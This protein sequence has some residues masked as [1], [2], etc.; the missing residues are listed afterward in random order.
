MLDEAAAAGLAV[1]SIGSWNVLDHA[2]SNGSGSV[3]VQVGSHRWPATRPLADARFE[4]LVAA[5]SDDAITRPS[6]GKIG[7]FARDAFPKAFS[8]AAFALGVG[9][10]SAVVETPRGFHV[11]VRTR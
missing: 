5:Y 4:A 8:D 6:G 7:N 1:A 3:F 11:I 9:G 2:V 10:V